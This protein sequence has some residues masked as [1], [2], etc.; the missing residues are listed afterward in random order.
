MHRV[1]ALVR[2]FRALELQ[3]DVAHY[4]MVEFFDGPGERVAVSREPG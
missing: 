3:A 2:H 4:Q 1:V